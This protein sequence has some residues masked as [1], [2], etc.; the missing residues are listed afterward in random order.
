ML[1]GIKRLTRP[2]PGDEVAVY[3]TYLL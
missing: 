1:W 3:R 2:A